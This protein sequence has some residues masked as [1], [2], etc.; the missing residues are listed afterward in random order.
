MLELSTQW[1][2]LAPNKYHL[3]SKLKMAQ[4]ISITAL[5]RFDENV[6]VFIEIK[7]RMK[8]KVI[9]KMVFFLLGRTLFTPPSYINEHHPL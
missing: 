6:L 9:K 5:E 8:T 1:P 4:N 3:L 7:L 2:D